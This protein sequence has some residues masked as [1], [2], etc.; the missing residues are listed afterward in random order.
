M[1]QYFRI[2]GSARHLPDRRIHAEELDQRLGRAGG[3]TL[4][5][6]G[7]AVRHEA[8][9]ADAAAIMARTVCTGALADAG[10]SLSQVDYLI[11]ASLCLQQP[12]P[13][14]A[15]LVQQALGAEAAGIASFDVHASCLGFVAAMAVVNGLF[16]SGAARRILV[17]C[18]ETALRGVNWDEPESACLMGD[19][20]A[21][22]VFEA[23]PPIEGFGL[24]IETFAEGASLCEVSGGGH[25]RSAL[26]YEERHRA[27]Y[28]FHMDGPSVHKFACRKLPALLQRVFAETGADLNTLEVVPH[29]ASG[30]ALELMAHRLNLP[31]DRFHVSIAEHGNLVAASIP[32]V[33]H[34]LRQHKPAGTRVMLLGTAAGYSQGVCIFTL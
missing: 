34:G 28:L 2:A 29:Q 17:V 7:V 18:A 13:C 10:S 3:T 9:G 12:L 4:A 8:M 11:D 33:L 26:D 1:L 30:P 6:T 16:A 22:F 27:K 20:A 15:A 31:R 5:R 19:G 32:F 14:N 23:T 24:A 25:R 21:A